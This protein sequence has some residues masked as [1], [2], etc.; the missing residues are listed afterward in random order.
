MNLE[1]IA[2]GINA[3]LVLSGMG[4]FIGSLFVAI[5][6]ADIVAAWRRKK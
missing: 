4:A 6:A 3:F 1:P 2:D 5:E